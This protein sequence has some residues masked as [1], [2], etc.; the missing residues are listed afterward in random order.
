MNKKEVKNTKI[1]SKEN[2]KEINKRTRLSNIERKEQILMLSLKIFKQKGFLNTTMEDIVK[3]SELSK[4]GLYYHYQ[5]TIDILYDLM[6]LGIKHRINI[7]NQSLNDIKKHKALK[8]TSLNTQKEFYIDF[9]ANELYKKIITQN[10]FM[11]IYVQFLYA[12]KDSA[13][14]ENLFNEL[15]EENKKEFKLVFSDTNIIEKNYDF[16]TDFI[17]SLIL[18][19]NILNSNELFLTKEI[20]IKQMFKLIL[21]GNLDENI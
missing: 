7:I 11:D 18:G 17:N 4:G 2:I 12:K 14:L 1:K 20:L 15:K 10:D 9:L 5:N 8:S 16:L 13:K 6:R 21:K 3:A 19:A